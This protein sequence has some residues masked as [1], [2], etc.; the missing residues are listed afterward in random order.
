MNA[1]SIPYKKN[2]AFTW[3]AEAIGLV[4]GCRDMELWKKKKRMNK[5]KRGKESV[6]RNAIGGLMV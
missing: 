1:Y 4:L 3:K 6:R 5:K 2:P